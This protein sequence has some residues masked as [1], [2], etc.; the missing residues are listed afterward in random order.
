MRCWKACGLANLPFDGFCA[1]EAWVALSVIAGALLAWSQMTCF[2]GALAK[3]EPKTMRY[4][5]L[6]VAAVFVHRGRD[7]IMRL[8]ETWPWA[9][10]TRHCLCASAR[11]LPIAAM[12]PG[13]RPRS[14][15]A[16]RDITRSNERPGTLT[17]RFTHRPVSSSLPRLTTSES[18]RQRSDE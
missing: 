15:S 7:L 2:D 5:V 16:G 13:A 17:P 9:Q 6:H 3:A 18:S 10:R 11:R 8:D 1:N 4:R 12:G 14:D